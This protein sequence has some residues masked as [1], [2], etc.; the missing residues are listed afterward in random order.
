MLDQDQD[1]PDKAF[2]LTVH[3]FN[4]GHVPI[5]VTVNYTAVDSDGAQSL[6]LDSIELFGNEIYAYELPD[7]VLVQLLDL[8]DAWHESHSLFSA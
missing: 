5:T 1:V 7:R 3:D 2:T 4:F 8:V 6:E